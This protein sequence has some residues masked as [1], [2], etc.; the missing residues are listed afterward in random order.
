MILSKWLT[1]PVDDQQMV[2]VLWTFNEIGIKIYN[3]IRSV[4]VKIWIRYFK[5]QNWSSKTCSI[6]CKQIHDLKSPTNINFQ[7]FDRYDTKFLDIVYDNIDL[8]IYNNSLDQTSIQMIVNSGVRGTLSQTQQLLGLREYVVGFNRQQS[9][10]P[11]L[12]S[13]NEGLSLIQFFLL[14]IFFIKRGINR[15]C[16]ENYKF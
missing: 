4:I 3:T 5:L 11:I 16:I 7:C 10:I 14:Y 1:K 9:R 2:S 13:Y 15:Y 12:S 6:N 8:K